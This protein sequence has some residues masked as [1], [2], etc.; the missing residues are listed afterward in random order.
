MLRRSGNTDF[1]AKKKMRLARFIPA[2]AKEMIKN[3]LR[4]NAI[5][6]A[7]K[8]LKA[9]GTMTDE[10]IATLHQAWGNDGFAAD[11]DFLAQL[12]TLLKG[13][14]VLEC[15]T[16]ATTLIENYVGVHKGFR[17]YCL[18]QDREWSEAAKWGLDAVHVFDSPLR[19]YGEYY[20]YDVRADLPSHFALIV[21]DGPYIDK[22]LGEPH[23]SAWRY[24]LLPWLRDTGRSFDTVLFDDVNDQRGV[25]LLERWTHEFGVR[26]ERLKSLYGECAIV[27]P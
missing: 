14:P 24:G 11:R 9:T 17:T 21:C 19:N 2:P 22:S 12:L 6:R 20:W 26:V 25:A 8:P 23:Y 15:G 3:G 10:E 7:L 4:F 1:P 18:E 27:R 5:R 16:G 13:G